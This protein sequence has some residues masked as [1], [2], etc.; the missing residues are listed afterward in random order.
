MGEGTRKYRN[1]IESLE[2]AVFSIDMEGRITYG[3]KKAEEFVGYRLDELLNKHFSEVLTQE[4]LKTAM[5]NFER[6]LRGEETPPYEVEIVR[7]DGKTVPAELSMATLYERGENVGRV[8]VLRDIT[9]RKQ[10]E[11]E[12]RESEERYRT[13]I[14]TSHEIIQSVKPDGHFDFVNKAWHDTL[15]YTKK[16]LPKLSLFD[17]IHPDSLEHCKKMFKKVLAGESALNV[18]AKFMAKDGST[19]FVEGNVAGRYIDGKLVATHGFF[20]DVTE[21]KQAEES[22]RKSEASLAEAQRIA[23]LGNWDWDIEK[24]ELLWSDEIY[25]IFGLAPQEFG[26]TYEGFLN[27]IHPDDREFVKKSVDEALYEGKPYRIDHR[28]VLPDGSERI[29]H[30]QAEVFFDETGKATRMIGT[31][32]DITERKRMEEELQKA[33]EELKEVDRVKSDI[34]SNVSH[35]LKTPITIAKGALELAMGEEGEK[36]R[37]EL[38]ARAIRALL[39][40]TNIV[41]DLVDIARVE[42]G[43]FKLRLKPVDLGEV[44]NDCLSEKLPMALQKEVEIETSI[45]ELPRIKADEAELKHVILNLLDNAIKFNRR[46]GE[47]LIRAEKKD[48]YIEVSVEDTGIGIAKDKLEKIFEPLTQLDPTTK[49]KYGGTGMGLTIVKRVVEMHGGKTWVESKAGKGSKFVFTLP[50]EGKG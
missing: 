10:A 24:N 23:H 6:G 38:L 30:E 48:R 49:R 22:L 1:L 41:N 40:Q 37:N 5:K 14:E 32:Q 27:S 42:R 13:L 2:D 31:V 43:E 16:E 26:A 17:I 29:V 25:R 39:H 50:L 19:V 8:G 34:I 46:G 21:H 28:I 18:E 47:V 4:S 33:Y 45:Q 36:E 12:L 15:G 3:N 44:V 9:K 20:R 35:E 7:K 11:E